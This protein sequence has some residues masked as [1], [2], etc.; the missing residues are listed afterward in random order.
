MIKF[1]FILIG[2]TMA[3]V[4]A[5]PLRF[6]AS[7]KQ[8][9]FLARQEV[10]PTTQDTAAIAPYPAAGVTPE[11]LFELPT[12]T[13][14]PEQ[15]YGP[16]VAAPDQTYGLPEST[17]DTMLEPDNTYGPPTTTASSKQVTNEEASV[18]ELSNL[19][20]SRSNKQRNRY[21]TARLILSK[22]NIITITHSKPI[23]V[24][25]LQ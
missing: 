21:R 23:L 22:D 3:L 14:K 1:C 4:A 20:Q 11:I 13:E 5:E 2:L 15:T 7:K 10:P 16:P 8:S 9:I 25:T 12:E 17:T 6:R 18:E 24:Y 19:V